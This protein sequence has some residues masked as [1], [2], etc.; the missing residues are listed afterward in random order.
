MQLMVHLA[1]GKIER[2][3][4]REDG[5]F[6]ISCENDSLLFSGLSNKQDVLLTHG[7][8][9]VDPGAGISITARS[10]SGIIAAVENASLKQYG[11][12]FHPEV[13]L[14]VNGKDMLANFPSK[15]L[16]ARLAS[17]LKIE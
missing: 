6:E 3:D 11:V 9:V 15:L 2:K 14:T 1:G 5:Q 8:S 10:S 16:G 17:R 4:T 7:D 13:D 12:Q